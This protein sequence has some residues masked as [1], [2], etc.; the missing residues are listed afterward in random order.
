MKRSDRTF[1]NLSKSKVEEIQSEKESF[2]EAL[3]PSTAYGKQGEKRTGSVR[4]M[5]A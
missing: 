2:A 1:S 5:S 3:L 4:P